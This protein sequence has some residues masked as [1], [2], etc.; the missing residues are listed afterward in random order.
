MVFKASQYTRFLFIGVHI[1]LHDLMPPNTYF[2]F[3]PYLTEQLSLDENRQEKINQLENDAEMYIRRNDA[4]MLSA[5]KQLMQER[6]P[7]QKATDWV[8]STL[9][10]LWN[11]HLAIT[12]QMKMIFK[13]D[14]WCSVCA[15]VSYAVLDDKCIAV[16]FNLYFVAAIWKQWHVGKQ[17]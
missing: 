17:I 5:A 14:L 15:K 8:N 12:F 10:K 9:S 2:R 16:S 6:K 7:L 3:N 4:K 13:T 11:E 1:I